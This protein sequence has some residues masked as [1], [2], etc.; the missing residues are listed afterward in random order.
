MNNVM[1]T[2]LENYREILLQSND[3]NKDAIDAFRASIKPVSAEER[4]SLGKE[5]F[6]L[7]STK[8]F[9]D[10]TDKVM[11]LIKK[12]ANVCY[13]NEK[14]DLP[15]LVCARKGHL[16]TFI[17]LIKAGANIDQANNYLTTSTMAAARHGH[18]MI[19]K[20][21]IA[22]GADINA[23]CLD[24]D[25]ALMSAKRHNQIKCFQ[26]LKNAQAS[27]NNRNLFNQTIDDIDGDVGFTLSESESVQGSVT[28]EDAKELIEEAKQK[29]KT[30]GTLI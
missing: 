10:S 22:L 15:L 27:L 29:M 16:N 7:V 28:E 8:Q 18:E 5:L 25:T 24:G 13:Q 1:L 20:L 30:L 19:L 14:G 17:V 6:E 23:R 2:E 9:K 21:L 11:E 12:G 26:L 3:L 4:E